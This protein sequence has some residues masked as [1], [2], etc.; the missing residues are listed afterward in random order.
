LNP[1]DAQAQIGLAGVLEMQEN[2]EQAAAYLRMAIAS[3]P[4]N[5]AAHYRLSKIARELHLEEESKQQM[6]LYLEIR[7]TDDKVKNLYRQMNPQALDHGD[8]T[9]NV[10]P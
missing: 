1:K 9:P 6:N 10:K 5:A 3:D 4:F 2:H 8:D 7:K